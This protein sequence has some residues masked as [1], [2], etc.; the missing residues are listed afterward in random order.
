[1]LTKVIYCWCDV[2]NG[3]LGD[4]SNNHNQVP[5]KT[6]HFDSA[7]PAKEHGDNTSWEINASL[8]TGLTFGGNNGTIYGTATEIWTQTSYTIWANNSGGASGLLQHNR[9]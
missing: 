1:M 4:C 3:K 5:G 8:P 9:S 2:Y 6:M 7:N